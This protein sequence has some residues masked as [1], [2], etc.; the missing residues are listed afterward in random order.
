M[1]FLAPLAVPLILGGS[2]VAT[3]ALSRG[4]SS[5]SSSSSSSATNAQLDPLI[6][7]QRQ[8]AEAAGKSG[9]ADIT[10]AR[11]GLDFVQNFY[12]KILT[13]SDD[14]LLSMLDVSG[15]TRNIDENEQLASELGVRGGRRAS[16]LGNASFS[17]DAALNNLLK[18][19]RFSAPDKLAQLNQ[20]LGNIGLGELST[21]VGAGA[22]ASNT[23]FGKENVN[24]QEADRRTSL[25]TGI[26]STVGTIAGAAL[27]RR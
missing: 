12:K 7:I 22:Q 6:Q 21:A 11:G 16:I 2:A 19:L 24:Q 14:E 10:S 4:G 13:G 1:P 9:Q 25:I 18:Q 3:A 17:R 26:M 23:I 8:I 5:G 20:V 15:A 27:G